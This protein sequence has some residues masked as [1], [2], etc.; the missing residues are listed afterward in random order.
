MGRREEGSIKDKSTVL[1]K[2][3][4]KCPQVVA[5]I[6]G[7]NV[8]CLVDSGS[9]VSTVTEG[10]FRRHLEENVNRP[11]DTSSWIA[12]T[13]TQ[14]LPVPYVGF[15]EADLL[16]SGQR[17][18]GMGFFVVKDPT[19]HKMAQRKRDVPGLIGSNILRRLVDIRRTQPSSNNDT[20]GGAITDLVLEMSEQRTTKSQRK[21]SFVKTGRKES[22]HLPATAARVVWGTTCLD[23]NNKT[24]LV[25]QV[26]GAL[27]GDVVLLACCAHVTSGVVP[28]LLVNIGMQDAWI[29]PKCRIGIATPIESI[30]SDYDCVK[31]TSEGINISPRENKKVNPDLQAVL[32][33]AVSRCDELR[34]HKR[35][36]FLDFL[37][38]NQDVFRTEGNDGECKTV[39]HEIYDDGVPV[40]LPP[41]RIPPNLWTEVKA[42]LDKLMAK[43]FIRKSCSPYTAALVVARKKDG[44]LRLCVDYRGL[45]ARTHKD[46][47]PLLRIEEALDALKGAKFFSTI[48]LADSYHQI[49][50][51]EKD[52]HKTAF[53]AGT[54]GLYEF[55][56]M[57]FGL[58]NAPATFQRL[59]TT[60]LGDENYSS[61]LIYLDDILVFS[62]TYE[63]MLQRLDMVFTRLRE[64]GLRVNP[65][66]CQFFR[67]EV[68]YLGHVVS[69]EGVATD[70]DKISA[71]VNWDTPTTAKELQSFMGL[72]GY[73]RR[74]VPGFSQ[75]AAPLHRLTTT[76]TSKR[77]KKRKTTEPADSRSFAE[78][79]DEEAERAFQEL[80]TRLTSSPILGYPDFAR[81]FIVETDASHHGIGAVL[82]Q[83]K[84]GMRKVIAYASR[85]LRPTER[86]MEN[87]ST[88]KLEL[89]AL[90][91][92]VTDKFRDYLLGSTFTVFTDNN[93]LTYLKTAKLGAVEL[94]WAAQLADF[95]FDII[96]RTG[97]SNANADALSRR[98][99]IGDVREQFRVPEPTVIPLEIRESY[100]V[101]VSTESANLEEEPTASSLT[102]PSYTSDDLAKLQSQDRVLSRVKYW[103]STGN[104]P[105][106][107]ALKREPDHVRKILRYWDTLEEAGGVLCRRNRGEFG[108]S[109]L[110]ILLPERLRDTV[111]ESLHDM[112]G[113]QGSERTLALVRRRCYWPGMTNDVTNYCRRCER[114]VIAK[115]PL[116][117]VRPPIGS[118][119]ASRP[120]QI[121]AV[122]YSKLDK[123]SDGREDVLVMTDVFTKYSIAV[124]TRDQSAT[125][126]AKVLVKEWFSKF[127]V[128]YQLHSDQGR[129][130]EAAIIH[131][132]CKL[133]DIRKSKTTAYHPE[134]NSQ[135]ERFNRTLHNLL[136]TLPPEEKRKWPD[137]LPT[138]LYAY[139]CTP[140]SST[141]FSPYQLMF[142]RQPRLPV[143]HLLN[144]HDEEGDDG[145]CS[146][147]EWVEAHQ[148]HLAMAFHMAAR[149]TEAAAE[150]RQAHYNKTARDNPIPVGATVLKK[151][152][153]LGRHKIQDDW[154]ATPYIV[155]A[156]PDFN[157][158][159]VQLSDGSGPSK[160]VTRRELQL[161]DTGPVTD[162]EETDSASDDEGHMIAMSVTPPANLPAT[163]HYDVVCDS[164]RLEDSIETMPR[165]STRSTKGQ[166]S[167][168]EHLP[169]SVL[170]GTTAEAMVNTLPHQHSPPTF[171]DMGRAMAALGASLGQIL[172]DSWLKVNVQGTP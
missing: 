43:N 81:P 150:A 159:T 75:I 132:L 97:K 33:E 90:K 30:D 74:F 147:G 36:S 51:A 41:R 6:A 5:K 145:G 62:Q 32:K 82:S 100:T 7:V 171:E 73:Y 71:I 50:V 135:C 99:T 39:E 80:K 140:H 57:S 87:Y 76:S 42:H 163:T 164:G 22:L 11:M 125:T 2:A 94:R 55:T 96:H 119:I 12:I 31:L 1:Q 153:H 167:N 138:L 143:D 169:K 136:R 107:Y 17:L 37:T 123:A 121:L 38:R 40:R 84:D 92:A 137:R 130:F 124:P 49:R 101:L 59:M 65:N 165:R 104:R 3:V 9:E 149:N 68:K 133:Y 151:R 83:D 128:P 54:G 56:R 98:G 63:E 91:W 79:W 105:S 72:A 78:K 23:H 69:A 52:I 116:P 141:G 26:H 122:D 102:L 4:G 110:Q 61:L 89:L 146:M 8:A 60:V 18:P 34:P 88:M 47:F 161:I 158:Y 139:N 27:P 103:C 155:V 118:L 85:G 115:A 20:R 29:S 19:D 45:N 14:G 25:E 156:R 44:S 162:V 117:K 152:H 142:G 166:H 160:N 48:D 106:I 126:T 67:K 131:Q 15:V 112:A 21:C 24:V 77:K 157:V 129:S 93:P 35:S 144:V 113:H 10:F 127:G 95:E 154:D 172:Q 16:I 70:P 120:L 170:S 108:D 134:G 64:H 53:R 46:A 109:H 58:C 13:S 66:K 148:K 86:N 114:C 28:M 168:R 111:L